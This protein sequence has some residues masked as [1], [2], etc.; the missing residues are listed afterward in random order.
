[1]LAQPAY[2]TVNFENCPVPRDNLL[3]NEGDGFKIAM[4]GLDGG[5]INIAVCS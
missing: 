3:G 4:A 2:L 5:R 1:M